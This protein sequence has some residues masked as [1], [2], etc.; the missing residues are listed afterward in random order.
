MRDHSQRGARADQGRHD[1][2]VGLALS[3]AVLH[4][5]GLHRG[6][7]DHRGGP[8]LVRRDLRREGGAHAEPAAQ[9]DVLLLLPHHQGPGVQHVAA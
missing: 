2:R 5:R 3:L 9:Q 7:S 6:G 8:V 4:G 1:R